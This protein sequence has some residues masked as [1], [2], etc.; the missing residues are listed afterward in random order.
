[1][2][3][4]ESLIAPSGTADLRYRAEYFPWS[5]DVYVN[6]VPSLLSPDSVLALVDAAGLG[7]IGEWRPSKAKTG[8]FG[9]F[10]VD[11]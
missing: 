10:R 7:G 5:A 9:T 3:V 6:F 8:I 4:G 2:E 11:L 1:M